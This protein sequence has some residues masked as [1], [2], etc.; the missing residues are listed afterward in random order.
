MGPFLVSVIT[1]TFG[2][3]TAFWYSTGVILRGYMYFKV[4]D[5]FRL[6]E[7]L[8]SSVFNQ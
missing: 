3:I 5:Y 2:G 1:P 8:F 6:E 7:G 4:T